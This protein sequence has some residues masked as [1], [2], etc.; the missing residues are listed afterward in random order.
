MEIVQV[1]KRS[2]NILRIMLSGIFLVA[3][4]NHVLFPKH[5]ASRLMES[6]VYQNL[7]SVFDA[8]TLVVVTGVGLLTGGLLLAINRYPRYAA[9][10]LLTLLIPITVSVQLQGWHTSG[11]LFKNVALA[12]ALLFFIV[13]KF[14][15]KQTKYEIKD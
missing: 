2:V 9:I 10:L 1:S 5:V 7:L 12:G 8:P 4:I 3:G 15:D 6:R 13:N 11:P 14:N